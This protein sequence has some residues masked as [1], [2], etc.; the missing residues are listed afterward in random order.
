MKKFILLLRFIRELYKGFRGGKMSS[1][2]KP[3]RGVLCSWKSGKIGIRGIKVARDLRS[4]LGVYVTEYT[5]G[6]A[7]EATVDWLFEEI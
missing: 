2:I 7:W 3:Q 5:E 1:P 6:E 4:F